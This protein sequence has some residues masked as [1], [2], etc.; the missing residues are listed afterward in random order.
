MRLADLPGTKGGDGL[1]RGEG[2][3]ALRAELEHGAGLSLDGGEDLRLAGGHA[4]GLLE[5]ERLAGLHR[6]DAGEH[7]PVVGRRHDHAV[8]VRILEDVADIVELLRLVA[9]DALDLAGGVGA[10]GG[11][12]VAHGRDLGVLHLARAAHHLVAAPARALRVHAVAR[13][14]ERRAGA[15]HH[16][17]AD[18]V[19]RRARAEG[20]AGRGDEERAAACLEEGSSVHGNWWVISVTMRRACRGRACSGGGCGGWRTGT[21]S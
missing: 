11:V 8:D 2:A 4:D 16:A 1:L 7:V 12:H 19:R 15:S 6:P 20:L 3:A 9:A 18:A 10:R 14:V 21:C 17:E 5:I 13:A